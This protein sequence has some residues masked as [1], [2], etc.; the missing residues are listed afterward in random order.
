MKNSNVS[1]LDKEQIVVRMFDSENDA[2]R[3]VLVGSDGQQIAESIKDSL[4]DLKIEFPKINNQ[5][6][7]KTVYI[8][9]PKIFEVPVI[10]KE[11]QIQEIE[12][13]II[14]TEIKVIEIEKPVVVPEVKIIEI[15]KHIIIKQSEPMTNLIK[16]ILIIQTIAILARVFLEVIHLK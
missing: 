9:D 12:K 11:V 2:Q 7:V 5:S 8:P 16:Y 15:E 6:E 4:K 14:I 13:P 3:V 1:L 10:I